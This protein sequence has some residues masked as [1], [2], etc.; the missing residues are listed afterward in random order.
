MLIESL[1]L[2]SV[3]DTA[4]DCLAMEPDIA[5]LSRPQCAHHHLSQTQ[6][7]NVGSSRYQRA[8]RR[9]ALRALYLFRSGGPRP[10]RETNNTDLRR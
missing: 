2:R 10:F 5:P 6:K 9:P 1:C 3:A 8:R 7:S 4:P